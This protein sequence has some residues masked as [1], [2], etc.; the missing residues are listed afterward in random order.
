M[1]IEHTIL[2]SLIHNE[3]YARTVIPY[4]T[5]D[6]FT[7]LSEKKIFEKISDFFL[8]YDD[9]P[10]TSAILIECDKDNTIGEETYNKIKETVDEI[11][12][13]ETN[14][15]D[16]LVSTTEEFCREKAIY[17]SIVQSISIFEGKDKT[18]KTDAIPD[19]LSKALAVS[20]DKR[21]GHD[22]VE[23]WKERFEW[24]HR[25]EEKIRFDIELLNKITG[26]GFSKKTLNV[27]IAG[28]NVG[29]T[30]IMCHLAANNLS[31]GLN[32]LYISGEMS[33]ERI[34]ERIDANLLNID[35]S[36]LRELPEDMFEKKI[37]HIKG[38]TKGRLVIKE[39]PTATA[40]V[41]HFKA[42]LS[43]LKLKKQF[44]PDIIYIDYINIFAS[45][46]VKL[47]GNSYEYIKNVAEE[48]RGL[49]VEHNLPIVTA[50]Q[51][52][53]EGFSSSDPEMTDTSESFGLPF[54]VDFMIAAIRNE[55]LD[56]LN[57]IMFKQ[58]KNRYEDVNNIKRFV[59]GI[60]R[61]KMRL[62][63]V[64]T[65]A[66]NISNETKTRKEKNDEPVMDQ[67]EF[68]NRWNDEIPKNNRFAEMEF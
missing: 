61:P 42:L 65:S 17:N 43:E 64:E 16:W 39:Y 11:S 33:E 30:L 5:Q 66:Q 28:T 32:V 9:T 60:D 57:Q 50:T 45:S 68:Q 27:I 37:N 44:I 21:I 48:F 36:Q 23:N 41:G 56:S 51:L 53:R 3:T 1:N 22:F 13:N 7:D 14:D 24:Y 10:T 2:R 55:E 26:G 15:L 4:I 12:T 67:T 52:N 34:G 29:K 8:N 63:D 38:K 58:L 20:F 47:Q 18:Y 46:R 40:H 6:Y 35:I 49:A 54:T 25:E 59:V 62:Y 31:D 19:I